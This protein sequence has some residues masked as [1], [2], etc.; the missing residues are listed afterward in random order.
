MTYI[1]KL[2]PFIKFYK[3]ETFKL[4]DTEINVGIIKPIIY[5]PVFSFYNKFKEY[6]FFKVILKFILR[7]PY[8]L[9]NTFIGG[10]F[11]QLCFIWA[12]IG[13]EP[14]T[15]FFS[16]IYI[17]ELLSLML[18]LKYF[19]HLEG[20][21]AYCLK[22]YGPYFMEKYIGNPISKTLAK[23]FAIGGAVNFLGVCADQ[24]DRSA[25]HNRVTEEVLRNVEIL[26]INKIPLNLKTLQNINRDAHAYN[27]PRVN[28]ASDMLKEIMTSFRKKKIII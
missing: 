20:V 6:I 11:T 4:V 13:R 19:L 10:M 26:K 22:E 12:F 8:W 1:Q 7:I 15:A 14:F 21:Y 28:L 24:Y 25:C 16:I 2:L 18:T 9:L 17:I 27:I 5:S 23:R 3:Y